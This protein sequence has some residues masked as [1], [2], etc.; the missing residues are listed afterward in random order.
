[1][2][3]IC[4]YYNLILYTFCFLYNKNG[5]LAK[6]TLQYQLSEIDFAD[7]NKLTINFGAYSH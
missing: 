6:Q 4:Q 1:M 5:L 7:L 2:Y 3:N